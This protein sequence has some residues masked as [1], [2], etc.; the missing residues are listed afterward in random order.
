MSIYLDGTLR[1][2]IALWLAPTVAAIVEDHEN[3]LETIRG[4]SNRND[5]LGRELIALKQKL[6]QPDF[7]KAE[8]KSELLR[9]QSTK[10]KLE[11]ELATVAATSSSATS[12][13][14]ELRAVLRDA[15][16]FAVGIASFNVERIAKL[17]EGSKAYNV[18]TENQAKINDLIQRITNVLK[19]KPDPRP[20]PPPPPAPEPVK[21][22]E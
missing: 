14:G 5:E 2:K 11:A 7:E 8:L 18:A 20:V 12:L 4:V 10:A 16:E 1:E 19:A 3:A 17:K 9:A 22:G 21:A 15:K 13:V 6:T